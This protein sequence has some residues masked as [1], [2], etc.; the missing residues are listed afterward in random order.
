MTTTTASAAKDA[1]DHPAI[2]ADGLILI[3][4]RRVRPLPRTGA[5]PSYRCSSPTEPESSAAGE[6]P[7]GP[8]TAG[9]AAGCT[10]HGAWR[11]AVSTAGHPARSR[12]RT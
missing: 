6:A 7:A 12:R 8:P 11:P 10:P 3:G 1:L 4:W 9:S 5:M 2:A